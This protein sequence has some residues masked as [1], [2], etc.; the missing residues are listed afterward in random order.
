MDAFLAGIFFSFGIIVA[1][2]ALGDF[3]TVLAG[4]I[5]ISGLVLS[6]FLKR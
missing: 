1:G 2:L 3:V 6:I 4:L 5:S